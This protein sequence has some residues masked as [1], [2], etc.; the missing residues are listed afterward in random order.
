[1]CRILRYRSSECHERA[2]DN[3]VDTGMFLMRHMETY[4]GE[5]HDRWAS[6][7]QKCWKMQLNYL[8]GRYMH[9]LL[10]SDVKEVD[11]DIKRG[12]ASHF[13]IFTRNQK[14]VFNSSIKHIDN[15]LVYRL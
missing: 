6:G 9:A 12:A 8:R 4:V 13:I 11:I 1:M 10:L 14:F 3:V 5:G 2:R 7:L 15:S